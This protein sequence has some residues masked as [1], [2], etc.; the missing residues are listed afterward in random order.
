MQ[1][2]Q[3]RFN[4]YMRVYTKESDCVCRCTGTEE[5]VNVFQEINADFEGDVVRIG[6]GED[7]RGPLGPLT[8]RHENGR[9]RRGGAR[10]GLPDTR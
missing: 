1:E 9:G 3:R 4:A 8:P 10:D 6:T 7:H 5:K 2:L